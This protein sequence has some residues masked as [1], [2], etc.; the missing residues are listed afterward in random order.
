MD[1]KSYKTLNNICKIELLAPAKDINCAITAINCGAD[2]VYIGASDFGARKKAGNSLEDIKKIVDYAHLFNVKIYVTVNT[3][4]YDNELSAVEKLINN[5]YE[6]GVDALIIQDLGI[7]KLNLPPISLHASTQCH[8]LDVEKIKFLKSFNISR[9]VLP[10]ELTLEEITKIKEKTDAELEFFVHGAL[11]VSY[12]GQCYMSYSIGRRSAN[13]GECAQPCRN[14]YSLVDEKGN[15]IIKDKYLLSLKDFCLI[16]ELENLSKAGVYSFKIEGRLKDEDYVKTVVS[17]YRQKIDKN[18]NLEKSS[19]G[20]VFTD[21]KPDLKKVFNRGFTTYN[22][23]HD[24]INSIDTPKNKGEFIGKVKAIFKNG[25]EISL[26]KGSEIK[27]NDGVCAFIDNDLQGSTVKNIQGNKIF[28]LSNLNLK[29]GDKIYKNLDFEYQKYAKNIV[30]QRKLP[31][32]VSAFFDRKKI[33]FIAESNKNKAKITLDNIFEPAKNDQTENIKK[34]FSKLGDTQF[35]TEKFEI[36][37][38]IPFI[39]VSK[40][41]EI[42]RNLTEMLKETILKNYKFIRRDLNFKSIPFPKNIENDYRLNITNKNAQLIYKESG[43]SQPQKGFE[44]SEHIKNAVLMRT[45][46]CMRKL[47]GKCPFSNS[48]SI[49]NMLP[50]ESEKNNNN[51]FYANAQNDGKLFLKDSFGNKY[52]LRFDCKNCVMEILNYE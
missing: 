32:S 21:F 39:P 31:I 51:K 14:K 29:I 35:I 3:V 47:A 17:A 45:K 5:L 33:T 46:N 44:V 23:G 20:I 24:D 38:T 4:L 43:I 10:R 27:L 41:N 9:I 12:S 37:G 52:P 6:I 19:D 34:Q 1:K 2:A 48:D 49:V 8:N 15:F 42:R 16:D 13:R 28:L 26:N 30:I 50:E 36:K 22:I 40:L 25:F 11:C 7:L 18:T